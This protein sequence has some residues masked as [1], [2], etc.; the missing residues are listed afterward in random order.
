[1][2]RFD[3]N[4]RVAIVTGGNG[5][6][7]LAMAKGLAEAGAAVLIAGR[8]VDKNERAVAEI[9]AARERLAIPHRPIPAF[10]TLRKVTSP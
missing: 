1:M 2:D 9:E 3:L 7:G 4:G 8:S 5:G 6:I 10:A